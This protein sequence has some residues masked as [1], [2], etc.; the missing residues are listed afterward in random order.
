MEANQGNEHSYKN[1]ILYSHAFDK[2]IDLPGTDKFRKYWVAAS[3][4]NLISNEITADSTNVAN[5]VTVRGLKATNLLESIG[6]WF[7]DFFTGSLGQS[8][9][10]YA[11]Y[12]VMADDD[13]PDWEKRP[14]VV[15]D[16]FADTRQ[17]RILVAT[18]ILI[19]SLKNM[20]QGKLR[21]LGNPDIK[22]HDVISIFDRENQMFGECE[23]R[24]VRHMYGNGVSF[25][26]E[27]EVDPII[28]ARDL[29]SSLMATSGMRIGTLLAVATVFAG[30][31]I[32]TG[33]LLPIVGASIGAGLVGGT[34]TKDIA[35][36]MFRY[37][38]ISAVSEMS[39]NENEIRPY[40]NTFEGF[41]VLDIRPL[42]KN[43][44]PLV[45]GI[46]GYNLSNIDA[47]EYRNKKIAESF[48]NFVEGI[49]HI[50]ATYEYLFGNAAKDLKYSI[51]DY[52]TMKTTNRVLSGGF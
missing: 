41:N 34:I 38:N 13:I 49:K 44:R 28:N 7:L 21:I 18:S 52:K 43:G 47:N 11:L 25:V 20:Y 6:T 48:D 36:S 50:G 46:N 22:P 24:T 4:I 39:S 40:L 27:L 42:T 17:S 1:S 8:D 9:G 15:T 12:T 16:D 30:A 51:N 14:L 26:T 2:M 29:T 35:N 31:T 45:A 33:G 10:N 23:V 32:A 19:N 5:Q 37:S 3:G